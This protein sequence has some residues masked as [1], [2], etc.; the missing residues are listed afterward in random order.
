MG[1]QTSAPKADITTDLYEGMVLESDYVE[2]TQEMINDY[3]K[4][5]RDQNPIHLDA[6]YAVRNGLKGTIAHG[7]FI[8]GLASGLA[9]EFGILTKMSAKFLST[10]MKFS[11]PVFSGDRIKLIMT[12]TD[13]KPIPK[14]T[15][16]K[17]TLNVTVVNQT[18]IP[19]QTGVWVALTASVR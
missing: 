6:E 2:V 15:A 9:Y 3:A 19:V 14:L 10:H 18:L 12:V 11:R 1:T 16:N 8:T 13:I 5:S 7:L 4:A 17:V